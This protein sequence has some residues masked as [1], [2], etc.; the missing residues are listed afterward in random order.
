[1][2]L[3]TTQD[4]QRRLQ[5]LVKG[6]AKAGCEQWQTGLSPRGKALIWEAAAFRCLSVTRA[7]VPGMTADHTS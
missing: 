1:M 6:W 2:G 7:R 3:P 4:F 5:L